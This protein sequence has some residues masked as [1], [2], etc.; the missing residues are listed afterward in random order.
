LL[1]DE[2][3]DLQTDMTSPYEHILWT[4]CSER[5]ETYCETVASIIFRIWGSHS[6]GYEEFCLLG[7]NAVLSVDNQLTFRKNIFPQTVSQASNQHETDSKQS[8]GSK[9][10]SETS[11]EFQRDIRRYIQE[12]EVFNPFAHS[13]VT[14]NRCSHKCGKRTRLYGWSQLAN[15]RR[16][17]VIHDR[18]YKSLFMLKKSRLFH[19][20]I[21]CNESV[22]YL[23]VSLQQMVMTLLCWISSESKPNIPVDM[24]GITA[25]FSWNLFPS[26]AILSTKN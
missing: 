6:G 5:F 24:S 14:R 15:R 7:Y 10:F 26:Q 16:D 1:A 2:R 4:S 22:S 19:L 13:I 9:M 11:V 12:Y 3:S 20:E 25:T 17:Y 18:D 8:H 21:T 23:L